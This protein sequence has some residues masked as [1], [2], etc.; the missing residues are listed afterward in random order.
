MWP[1]LILGSLAYFATRKPPAKS[2]PTLQP[3]P[4]VR[5]ALRAAA[6]K[7]EVPL[8][9]MIAVAHTESRFKPDET[10]PAGAKGLMQLMPIIT[11]KYGIENPYDPLENA[12]GG[13]RLLATLHKQYGNWPQTL[14]AY[15]WGTGNVRENPQT[16]QWPTRTQTYVSRVVAKAQMIA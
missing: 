2:D 6:Q 14:A 7:H 4:Y 8:S 1:W 13:A 3:P 15:N 5:R 11:Q 12:M 10:S 9:I 16:H